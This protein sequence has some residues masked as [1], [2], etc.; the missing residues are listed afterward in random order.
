MKKFINQTKKSAISLILILTTSILLMTATSV[1]AHDP[2]WQLPTHAFINVSPNPSGINQ[3]ALIVVWL[4]RVIQG[5]SITNDIR[6]EGYTLEITKPD[7]TTVNVNWPIVTDT[8]SSAFTV[9]VPDQVGTYNLEF[10]FPG[11]VYDFGGAYQNDFYL[12][13]SA[14][15]T[16]TVQEE[17][18]TGIPEASLPTEYWTRPVDGANHLWGEIS[19]N[20]LNGG[21]VD[22]RWQDGGSSPTT[23][24]ILWSKPIELGGMVGGDTH[25]TFY[26]GY[27]Y[28]R[29]F[30][31][32]MIVGGI[33]YYRQPL[34]HEGSGGGFVAADLRTG[35]ELWRRYDVTP[36]FAQLY[37]FE[38]PNQH[39]V[40]GGTLWATSGSKWIGIDAFTGLNTFNLTGVPGGTEVYTEK[41]EIVRYVLNY[42]DRR[43]LL[44][45]NT[46]AAG[47]AGTGFNEISWRPMGKEIDAS[48]AYSWNVSIPDLPGNSN[49][50]IVGIIPGD[51]ILGRS[52][53]ITL[54]SQARD[55][56]PD[57]WTMW[58]ISDKPE[59]R[60]QLLW[61]RDY[62]APANNIT[63]MLAMQP[64]DPINRV[65]TMTDF[66]TGQR[67]GYSIDNGDLLWGPV[68]EQRA[69]QYYSNRQGF[70][71]YG[72]L[73]IAG[74]GGEIFC[75]SMANGSLLW[76]FSDTNL[77]AETPWGL[78]PIQ[79]SAVSNGVVYAFSGEHS[80]NTPLYKG[81][82]AYA[83][84]AFTGEELWNLLG[85]SASGLGT[86]IAPIAIA[87]G[88]LV[89]LNAY[90]GSVYCVGKGPS[91]VTVSAPMSATPKGSSVMI[92]GTVT[93]ESPGSKAKGSP[94]ISDQ[95]MSAWM[96]YKFMQ[97]DRPTEAIG[98]DV[99]IQIVD[100]NGAYAWIGT[101][102]SDAY[103]NYGYS[104]IPQ[105]EG[106]YTIIATFDGSEAYYGSTST[107]YLVVDPAPAQITIP[108]YPGYQGPSAQEIANRVISSLPAN[109][110]PDQIGQAVIAQLPEY[111]EPTV[112]P[113]YTMIDIAIIIAVAV[114]AVL[115]VYTLISVK[116]QK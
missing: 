93:D 73:Y 98:V 101:A 62:P 36:S 35:E 51:L 63:R 52:S 76:K 50:A 114:V 37:D 22:D 15:T 32:P 71:A 34:N 55:N 108:P 9:Y 72:N 26:S 33:L 13:S 97:K 87:D 43:L 111:P 18:I 38:S 113:E 80:P 46:A 49:P 109:P 25:T 112:V 90:D 28:E 110:T 3:P 24:H 4:E 85:W 7:G 11:Q 58:A 5:A 67:T 2:A 66:Q 14:T 16:L 44:W 69:F 103:G 59:T 48:Q 31:N 42:A 100:P 39:G 47:V 86:S 77:G 61:I 95:Y 1:N 29:R 116:K 6:F 57:P 65:W 41:G 53:G 107:T 12:P 79:L 60:G 99:R 45:N 82:R 83:V 19:S 89:Y 10:N 68:G 91:E 105:T 64:L 88:N 20:W 40:V 27:S 102:T 81:Y 94:A 106:I 21:D 8:T 17:T 92:T 78:T 23:S 74:Y 70:P 96:E 30:D 75:Y 104:F 56:N 54:T 84:D 115:V